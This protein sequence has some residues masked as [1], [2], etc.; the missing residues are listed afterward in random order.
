MCLCTEKMTI[1]EEDPTYSVKN[2][3]EVN[4]FASFQNIISINKISI[5]FL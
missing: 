2:Q 5:I 1:Y 3:E 4:D